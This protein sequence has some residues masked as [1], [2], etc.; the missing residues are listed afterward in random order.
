MDENTPGSSGGDGVGLAVHRQAQ[1]GTGGVRCAAFGSL[2]APWVPALRLGS[3][4]ARGT[5][6]VVPPARPLATFYVGICEDGVYGIQLQ[7]TVS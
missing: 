5:E 4:V 7:R 6:G 3:R 1:Q 2:V